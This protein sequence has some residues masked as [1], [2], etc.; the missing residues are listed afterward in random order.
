M[1]Q[2]IRKKVAKMKD[3]ILIRQSS[4]PDRSNVKSEDSLPNFTTD[5]NR[6]EYVYSSNEYTYTSRV[7]QTLKLSVTDY[8][9]KADTQTSPIKIDN[10]HEEEIFFNTP[11]GDESP[12]S[13]KSQSSNC[14]NTTY[15]LKTKESRK[16][17]NSRTSLRKAS[18]ARIGNAFREMQ[19]TIKTRK[20]RYST[21]HDFPGRQR[22]QSTDN[23]IDK[24]PVS[25]SASLPNIKSGKENRKTGL[26]K[27]SVDHVFRKLSNQKQNK[28]TPILDFDST[29]VI[30]FPS[31]RLEGYRTKSNDQ[32]L[33]GLE[34]RLT[35]SPKRHNNRKQSNND[36]LPNSEDRDNST[37][38]R[39]GNRD[40][41]LTETED[42]DRLE[43]RRLKG[44]SSSLQLPNDVFVRHLKRERSSS[45]DNEDRV[46]SFDKLVARR[47]N[48]SKETQLCETDL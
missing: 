47:L 31:N 25:R 6:N 19:N 38:R 48:S 45:T 37:A 5:G 39:N 41:T 11:R 20:S 2:L 7:A 15:S 17:S 33:C 12:M 3:G 30:S 42:M 40:N 44:R 21:K 14:N 35:P 28:S 29:D 26:S 27:K 32:I 4:L 10:T 18:V 43:R 9:D 23:F 1:I 36:L 16:I 8:D 24:K 34:N 46:F 22:S 13:L